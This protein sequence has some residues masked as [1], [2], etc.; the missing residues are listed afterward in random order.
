MDVHLFQLH[1][2][3]FLDVLNDECTEQWFCSRVVS[4][5]VYP[6]WWAIAY[7]GWSAV[8]Y[9]RKLIDI[10]PLGLSYVCMTTSWSQCCLEQ[11]QRIKDVLP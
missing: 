1:V 4:H 7:P 8:A 11:S 2:D 10:A 3:W 6:G 5:V 9:T